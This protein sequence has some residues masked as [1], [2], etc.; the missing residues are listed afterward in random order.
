MAYV[1][2][3][4]WSRSPDIVVDGVTSIRGDVRADHRAKQ[5]RRDKSFKKL[6]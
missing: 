5:D 4:I 1:A 6:S 2:R 3:A